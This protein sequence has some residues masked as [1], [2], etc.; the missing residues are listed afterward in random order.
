MKRL[1]WLLAGLV[2]F[3]KSYPQSETQ[4]VYYKICASY[5]HEFVIDGFVRVRERDLTGDEMNFKELNIN[6]IRSITVFLEKGFSNNGNLSLRFKRNLLRGNSYKDKV[7]AY[8]GT[9]IDWKTGIDVSPTQFYSIQFTYS[10]DL[11]SL[12]K[13]QIRYHAG[14]VY[15]YI[16]FYLDGKVAETSLRNEVY[17]NFGKQALLYPVLGISSEINLTPIDHINLIATGSYIPKFKSFFKEGGNIYIQYKSLE[18]KVCYDKEISK[19]NISVGAVLNYFYL[20]QES[21]EDTN[22][23]NI[24]KVGPVLNVNYK[25]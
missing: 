24:L 16:N 14:I 11:M 7:I 4:N 18:S 15:D 9:L 2:L 8:N 1:L 10:K 21:Q 5:S 22:E 12:N 19:F 3:F 6:N 20:W 25:F 23:I 17:E 13:T